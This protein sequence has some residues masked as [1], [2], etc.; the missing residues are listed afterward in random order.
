MATAYAGVASQNIQPK[1]FEF[2]LQRD[3]EKIPYTLSEDE[4]ANV[5]FRLFKFGENDVIKVD[6]S[7]MRTIKIKVRPEVNI[8]NHKNN[9]AL[10]IREGLFIQPM[11]EVKQ[12]KVIKLSWVSSD[13]K[14]EEIVA[15]MSLFGRVTRPPV[16][17]GQGLSRES[18]GTKVSRKGSFF[19][20]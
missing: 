15:V 16:D 19:E 1:W 4:L 12:E 6:Q 18:S 17:G 13:V 2:Y 5:L 9:R 20:G 8:E 7:A 14:D 10:E 3:D 11:K